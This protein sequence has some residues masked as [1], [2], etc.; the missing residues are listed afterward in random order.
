MTAFNWSATERRVT[1][2]NPSSDRSLGNVRFRIDPGADPSADEV[3]HIE[4]GR[5]WDAIKPEL[6]VNID[7]PLLLADTSMES[8]ELIVSAILRDRELGIFEK[9]ESWPLDGLPD[10]GYL[11]AEAFGRCSRSTRM[12]VC[13]VVSH[14]GTRGGNGLSAVQRGTIV[15]LKAFKIRSRRQALDFPVKFVNPEDMERI[16]GL[17]RKTV[18][19]VHWHGEDVHRAPADLIEVW[20]NKLYEDIFRALSSSSAGSGEEYIGR[21]IAAH[22]Y[23]EL[24]THVLI[25]DDDSEESTSLVS[26]IKDLVEREFAMRLDD[27]RR[28]YRSGPGGRSR[29][30][31]WC[32]KLSN[33]D[34]GFAEL[35]F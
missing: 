3:I 4:N 34:R 35:T 7:V 1:S 24:L 30:M 11:L 8:D 19:H 28:I 27:M 26:I 18:F 21:N 14:R 31:P 22:V 16:A 6:F 25:A 33:S 15:A 10:D 23:A 32:W 12:D 2:L 20:L 9:V 5:E 29:V 13:V 17:D